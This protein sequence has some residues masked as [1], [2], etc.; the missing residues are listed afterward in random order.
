MPG[1]RSPQTRLARNGNDVI[2]PQLVAN[3]KARIAKEPALQGMK[4]TG[5]LSAQ[6]V[7]DRLETLDRENAVFQEALNILHKT[8]QGTTHLSSNDKE[9]LVSAL[10]QLSHAYTE[11]SGTINTTG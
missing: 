8:V 5:A 11:A 9:E 6:E 3:V 1:Q 7:I 10:K 4:R 2:E